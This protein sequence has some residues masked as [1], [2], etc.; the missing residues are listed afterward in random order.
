[1]NNPTFTCQVWSCVYTLIDN[2]SLVPS[3]K[4]G[5]CPRRRWSSGLC[6][7]LCSDDSDCP[8]EE[9]CCHNGCG[10]QCTAPYTGSMCGKIPQW[11]SLGVITYVWTP[12]FFFGAS[13]KRGRCGLPQGTPM[14]AE[15]CYHDGQ[16]PGEQKCCKTTCGHA[17]SEPCWLDREHLVLFTFAFP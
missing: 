14:C 15:Y 11:G 17:C 13:V 7:E 12:F 16:C 5:V 4:P 2:D 1:M 8:S 9:K 10:H 3:A 6:A